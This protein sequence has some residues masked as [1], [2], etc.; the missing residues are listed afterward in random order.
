M[1]TN[2]NQLLSELYKTSPKL[3]NTIDQIIRQLKD[4]ID[5]LLAIYLITSNRKSAFNE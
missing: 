2:T 3:A 5:R 1:V 4:F